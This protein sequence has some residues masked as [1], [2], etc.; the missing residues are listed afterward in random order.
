MNYKKFFMPIGG[1]EELKERIYGALLVAKH[2][3]VHL[4]ILHSMPG[5]NF[6][7][8]I[9]IHIRKELEEFA[10][11]NRNE[12]AIKFNNLL[13]ELTSQINVQVSKKLLENQATVSTFIQLGDR[14][15][16]V[17]KES[18]FSD[19]VVAASPPNGETTATFE[20]AVLHSGKPVIMIPRVMTSFKTDS[21]LIAW[22]NSQEISRAI[23]SGIDIIK[24]AKRVHLISTEEYSNC[25][26]DLN[27]IEDYLTF[28]KVKVTKELIKTKLHPGEAL[29]ETAQ[30]GE[31]DLIITGAYGHK[32]LKEIVFGG[33]TK[34]LLKHS[35]IPVFM[36]H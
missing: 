27:K 20:A 24:E 16:M 35:N 26:D 7:K 23:T 8:Q 19:L 14:S 31:F 30:K 13:L 18:K 5:L 6:D 34:Y 21:I 33:T 12:E 15:T 11:K 29:L 25:G 1:G 10:L 36:S 22:N 2:F 4:E 3:K 9:P 32:G 17:V 28:H